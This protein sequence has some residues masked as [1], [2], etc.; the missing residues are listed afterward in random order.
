MLRTLTANHEP[1]PVLV[2]HQIAAAPLRGQPFRSLYVAPE[3]FARYTRFVYSEIAPGVRDWITINEPMVHLLGG[4]VAC[5]TPPGLTDMKKV[6][7]PL[8]GLIRAHAASYHAL[9]EEAARVHREI[10]VGIAH[11]LRVIEPDS[12]FNPLLRLAATKMD[13]AFNWSFGEACETGHLLL[14]VPAMVDIDEQIPEAA[15]TQD[16]IGVNYYSRDM[17]SFSVQTPLSIELTVHEGSPVT[18][19]GW[20]IYPQGFYQVLKAAAQHYPGKPILVTENG[21]A[22]Y[23]DAQRPEFLTS[24]LSALHRAISE[25]V[26]VEGYCHWSLMD[27]FEWIEGFGP[28]FGLVEIDYKTQKR[29]PRPS[30]LLFTRITHDNGF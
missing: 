27:N 20:E 2:Y 10:R 11:H 9:H 26:P 19:L 21:L 6:S 12:P 30:A 17:V 1:I 7:A 29:T 22:D 25:G 28:R 8:V 5:L 14:N 16:F 3:A 23:R 24:H 15:H 13:S 4:Y 18:D